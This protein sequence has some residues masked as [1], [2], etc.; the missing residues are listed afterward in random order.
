MNDGRPP[1][2]MTARS[3]RREEGCMRRG[4]LCL[5][6]RWQDYIESPIRSFRGYTELEV[7]DWITVTWEKVAEDGAAMKEEAGKA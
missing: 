4:R 5:R 1:I 2:P 7:D 6:L 3:T